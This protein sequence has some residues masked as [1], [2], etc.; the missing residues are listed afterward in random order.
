ME[1]VQLAAAFSDFS[2][3]G[4]LSSFV[5]RH[6]S[7]V[8]LEN[9]LI[10]SL[11]H[12]NTDRRWMSD[13]ICQNLNQKTMTALYTS[14]SRNAKTARLPHTLRDQINR[15]LHNN[16]QAKTILPWLNSLPEVKSLL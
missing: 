3:F 16:E 4:L 15:R 8:P 12:P 10:K 5:I 9:T 2:A 11:T 14:S 6:F 1:C 7:A 13:P